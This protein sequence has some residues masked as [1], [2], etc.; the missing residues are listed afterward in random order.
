M[1]NIAAPHIGDEEKSAVMQVLESGN[2]V[3]G[4]R[5]Q[6]FEEKFAS[7]C[8]AKYA[9]A[10]SSG[11]TALHIALMANGIQSGDEVITSP[12]SFIASANCALYV[13]ARPVF[14]DIESDY[15]TIDPNEIESRI[16]SKTRAIIP[17]HLFG[18]LCDMDKISNIAQKYNLII[19]EDAC[20]AHGA[21]YKGKSAGAWGIACYSFYPTK[22]M[23]TIEGGMITTND[24][25]IAKKAKLIRNHGSPKRYYHD[26]L[27]YNF[28]MTDL[29]AAIGIQQIAKVDRWNEKRK[30]NAA[31]LTSNLSSNPNITPPKVRTNAEHVFHQYTVKIKERETA[32]E[33]LMKNGIG[34]GVYYPIPIHQQPLYIDLGYQ[35]HLPQ[36]EIVAE[37]VLSLPVHPALSRS[38]LDKIIKVLSHR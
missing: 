15:F 23:T 21:K 1:I 9:V 20:Q 24:P 3:Q 17:V 31:Y 22:N 27:G 34:F 8:G 16:T 5:V 14:A 7:W 6:E 32:I 13:G 19:I 36:S 30:K 33:N 10:T 18:Q 25:E 12:F 26:C 4:A 28:R 37:E 2:L 29:S 35:D 38:D 11:T